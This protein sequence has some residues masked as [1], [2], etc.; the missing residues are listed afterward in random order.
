MASPGRNPQDC[1]R[2]KRR[3]GV[4]VLYVL[5]GSIYH[6]LHQEFQKGAVDSPSECNK[7]TPEQRPMG[8]TSSVPSAPS[9][10]GTAWCDRAISSADRNTK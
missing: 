1:F 5:T 7:N 6:G 2:K 4:H 9:T 10:R 8:P 3:L